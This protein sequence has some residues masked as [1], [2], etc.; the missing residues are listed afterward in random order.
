MAVRA[1]V[2]AMSDSPAPSL[3]RLPSSWSPE[4]TGSS[5]PASAPPWP[6][7]ARPCVPS[8]G[9]PAPPRCC[10]ASR[11]GSGTSRIPASR[12]TSSRV[13]SAVVTTVHPMG[14]DRDNQ[15]R[16]GV[17]GTPVIARAAAAAGVERLVHISTAA[18]YDR[19]PEAGDV[20]ESAP[21]GRSGTTPPRGPAGSWPAA[22]GDGAGRRPW[23]S[24]RPWP[25]STP[26]CGTRP[27]GPGRDGAARPA[28][29]RRG[30]RQTAIR[31][32]TGAAVTATAGALGLWVNGDRSCT[33]AGRSSPGPNMGPSDERDEQE[34]PARPGPPSAARGR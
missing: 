10:P 19:S 14:T 31:A 4:P 2:G 1:I 16:I 21:L 15:H 34:G 11:S 33:H 24:P 12:P 20:D 32:S 17:E 28:R 25:R 23:T 30:R 8:Y 29:P 7:A 6:S 26:G 18:V 13:P 27:A 3:P 22:P 9:A 5:V